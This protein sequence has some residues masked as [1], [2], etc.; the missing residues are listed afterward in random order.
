MRS[1]R[2][3]VIGLSNRRSPWLRG[4]F[5][6]VL[7]AVVGG[8]LGLLLQLARHLALHQQNGVAVVVYAEQF[9]RSDVGSG[10]VPGTLRGR[11]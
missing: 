1:S 7:G 9:G 5:D 6:G 2:G 8:E 3:G 10:C 4:E 11:S